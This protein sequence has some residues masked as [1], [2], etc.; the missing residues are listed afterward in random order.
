MSR[1]VSVCLLAFSLVACATQK[2]YEGDKLPVSELA[3]IYNSER[4]DFEDGELISLIEYVG[5]LQVGDS[6]R[7]FPAKVHVKPGNVSLKLKF[8]EF[9]FGKTMAQGILIVGGGLVGGI[10]G[11]LVGGASAAGINADT[12]GFTK[13]TG[14]VEEGRSY[15]IKITS[16]SDSIHDISVALVETGDKEQFNAHNK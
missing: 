16:A 4:T 3:T 11:P 15:I 12:E 6:F 14:T 7:G 13:L 10:A 2:A 9:S 8:K 1:I 5:D